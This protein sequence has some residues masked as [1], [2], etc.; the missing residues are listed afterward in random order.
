MWRQGF[1]PQCP[2]GGICVTRAVRDHVQDRLGLAFEELGSLNLKNIARPVE[3]FVAEAAVTAPTAHWRASSP[4]LP[5]PDKPSIAVLPFANLSSDPEQEYFADGLTE[6]ILTAL[7][8]FT[9]LT[10]IARNSTFVYKGRAVEHRRCR[11]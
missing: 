11:T 4:V 2:P 10:V 5:L 3:A 6:D 8:R 9:Q 1:R 7:A